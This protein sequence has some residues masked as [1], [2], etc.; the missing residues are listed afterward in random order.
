[1][2]HSMLA[3]TFCR[4]GHHQ[5]LLHHQGRWWSKGRG[6][7]Q[8]HPCR[9]LCCPT[10]PV[11]SGQGPEDPS[12]PYVHHLWAAGQPSHSAAEQPGVRP[13]WEAS[14]V[15]TIA[16]LENCIQVQAFALASCQSSIYAHCWP[17]S[18]ST[19]FFLPQSV[20]RETHGDQRNV[21]WRGQRQRSSHLSTTRLQPPPVRT[22]PC[23][24]GTHSTQLLPSR[25]TAF[26]A[27]LG[28]GRSGHPHC[29]FPASSPDCKSKEFQQAHPQTRKTT[30]LSC[31]K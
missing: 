8:L 5:M 29:P 21:F 28:A 16:W 11:R 17:W 3:T 13:P 15:A 27:Q 18:Q 1:M 31:S 7:A 2:W 12:R 4:R 19:D 9:R 22:R 10:L 6:F 30:F 14:L 26:S 24:A 20:A 23:P 25:Q